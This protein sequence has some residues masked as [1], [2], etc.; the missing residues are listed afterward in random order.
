MLRTKD[1]IEFLENE[2]NRP[3]NANYQKTQEYLR[4]IVRRLKDFDSLKNGIDHL[5]TEMT[6]GELFEV[7]D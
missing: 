3:S 4:V 1:L 7:E 2:M 5:Y 6:A